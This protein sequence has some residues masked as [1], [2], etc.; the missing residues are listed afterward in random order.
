M[1]YLNPQPTTPNPKLE[2]STLNRGRVCSRHFVRC[3][4]GCCTC[5]P[6]GHGSGTS[7]VGV[8]SYA[9]ILNHALDHSTLSARCTGSNPKPE[10]LNPKP[11]TLSPKPCNS[12][13]TA[14][15]AWS[16]ESRCRRPS[17]HRRERREGRRLGRPADE[18]H[19]CNT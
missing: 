5:S 6:S 17:V 8:S 11:Q 2:C 9:C 12:V 4:I 10:T 16:P 1:L 7:P 13:R 15:T 14:Q 19:A 3:P 18:C